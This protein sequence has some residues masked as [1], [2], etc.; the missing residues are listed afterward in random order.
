MRQIYLSYFAPGAVVVV[1]SL[2]EYEHLKL[3]AS[4]V[5]SLELV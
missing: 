3:V 1:Y 5:D 4:V 2:A